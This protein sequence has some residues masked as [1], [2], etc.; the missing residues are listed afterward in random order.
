M[1]DGGA[2]VVTMSIDDQMSVTVKQAGTTL[3]QFQG[4]L[5]Q[6]AASVKKLED[7]NSSASTSFR[8]LV[9]SMGM[10]RFAVMDL[11]D[12][13]LKLPMHIMD[14]AGALEKTSALLGALSHEL[15]AH[16]KAAE[17]AVNFDYIKRMALSSPFDIAKLSDAFVR[18]KAVGLDPAAG[19]MQVLVDSVASFGGTSAT[20]DHAILAIQE[21]LA[22][23]TVSLE[24]L[25]RQLARAVPD[26]MQSMATG[27]G[28][29]MEGL[30]TAVKK[31][32]VD[33][34]DAV[35]KM[36]VI[37][38]LKSEGAAKL[39]M[40]TWNG[41]TA[42]LKT[43]MQLAA[44]EI[45]KSGFGDAM[46]TAARDINSA[47][48]SVDFRRLAN[49]YGNSMAHIVAD[50]STFGK[51]MFDHIE[52]IKTA[53]TVWGYYKLAT[54][55]IG[56]ALGFVQTSVKSLSAAYATETGA[57]LSKV[58][59]E[60]VA[61]L[62]QAQLTVQATRTK[63]AA[64]Q[65]SIQAMTQEMEFRRAMT[66]Q[67]AE[68]TAKLGKLLNAPGG[69][70]PPGT[71]G[72]M[73]WELIN[74]DSVNE[75]I[76]NLN[77]LSTAH[78]SVTSKIETE[79][80]ATKLAHDANVKAVVAQA[81]AVEGLSTNV[82]KVTGALGAMK[83]A[84]GMV[85]TAFNALG[86]LM[87]VLNVAI[88]A[89]I[90]LFMNWGDAAEEAAARA[91]RIKNHLAGKD[92]LKGV[93]NETKN[94][95]QTR[96]RL[97]KIIVLQ[98]KE[99]YAERGG[100]AAE[101]LLKNQTDLE[102]INKE[103]A[104]K[105]ISASGINADMAREGSRK[106]TNAIVYAVDEKLRAITLATEAE[107]GAIEEAN[108]ARIAA[109]GSS[110]ALLDAAAKDNGDREKNLVLKEAQSKKE[111]LT[112][113]IAELRKGKEAELGAAKE[114]QNE[115]DDANNKIAMAT[116]S[117]GA[118]VK[119]EDDKPKNP[120]TKI[121]RFIDNTKAD[122][123]S[124][125]AELVASVAGLDKA[126]SD[127]SAAV[128]KEN[129]KL[130][131]D[132]YSERDKEGQYVKVSEGDKS[133]AKAA[134][135]EMVRLK[136]LVN[137]SKAME[138]RIKAM[139]PEYESTLAWLA[140]PTGTAGTKK[141]DE[142]KAFLA[143]LKENE[144]SMEAAAKMAHTTTDKIKA[145]IGQGASMAAL[146]D[147]GNELKPLISNLKALE[148]EYQHAL[149]ILLDP[150]GTVDEKATDKYDKV[151]AHLKINQAQLKLAA[152]DSAKILGDI[153]STIAQ[154]EDGA[155]KTAT[156]DLSKAF[157]TLVK[158]NKKMNLEMIQDSRE[159]IRVQLTEENNLAAERAQNA[160]RNAIDHK[161][162]LDEITRME[163]EAAKSAILRAEDMRLKMRTPLEALADEW[164]MSLKKMDD[165][166]A[167]WADG[168]VNMVVSAADTGKL[169]I[170]S[171]VKSVLSDILKIEAQKTLGDPLKGGIKAG[172]D[173]LKSKVTNLADNGRMSA[174]LDAAGGVMG[175]AGDAVAKALQ[176]VR[177]QAIQTAKGLGDMSK[178]GIDAATK[179]LAESVG[180]DA[181]AT[182]ATT[183]FAS[184]VTNASVAVQGFIASLA[185]SGGGG[186][187]G[188]L[189]GMFDGSSTG[190][191]S[192]YDSAKYVAPAFANG[193]IMSEFGS[194]SLRKYAAGGV[195]NSPQLAIYG[196]GSTNEAYVP[197]PDGRS[198]PVT[199]SGSQQDGQM[200]SVTVNVINQ[201]GTPV[202]AQQGQPRFDGKQMI[203]D[204]VLSAAS[205]PGSFRD[206][207]KGAMR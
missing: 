141:A 52:Q 205:Q 116:N 174:P 178:D 50:I 48:D 87:T 180:Q 7:A 163:V 89:G 162:S 62:E 193:G 166:S 42:H 156:I 110:K 190:S 105:N 32:T 197:L 158:E 88:T 121:R 120:E 92:D 149:K 33:S 4:T 145:Q 22:K 131:T 164:Q 18:L 151:L 81:A 140:N 25:R 102:R 106:E 137:D 16:G 38:S 57:L 128:A 165:A 82:T 80:A 44:Q 69:R 172:T 75:Q 54:L 146:L 153:N 45:A 77:R 61:L 195:A 175:G 56:P 157:D 181:L 67:M 198:I 58:N 30:S 122:I 130:E 206:G 26:A 155:R 176:G 59:T 13:F 144:A 97:Q 11:N 66:V 150:L 49:D 94:L 199:M 36:L 34:A 93:E 124:L 31:G 79:L 160:I 196:E 10:L 183:T 24:Q 46:K 104:Q 125:K 74:K 55:A 170:S 194:V 107:K 90:Y 14:T 132:I 28:L 138:E 39:M 147:V 169:E 171:F 173:W 203:L 101:T 27:M 73:K 84:A 64:S 63:V 76:A 114:L 177:E 17:A 123:A 111:V 115:L 29:T 1:A 142:F 51:V 83:V 103:I 20:M 100:V 204:V 65:E 37:M 43:S 136:D 95:I 189:A 113:K 168:F 159:R 192:G 191:G 8:H 126:S 112:L 201:S 127:V 71:Q 182:S 53:V 184:S 200:P 96:D 152:G 70:A 68:E 133:A 2:I 118:N 86:G 207:M 15:T 179:S 3:Q 98:I 23:G 6:T 108:K 148:P 35:N 135:E 19:S 109:A 5:N 47:M 40:E 161:V 60:R 185:S 129:S 143:K 99:H 78:T 202:A 41:V 119:H 9:T 72:Y 186:G 117:L 167:H 134:V 91:D 154:V 187:M 12:I 139:A 188:G 21:M 85:G